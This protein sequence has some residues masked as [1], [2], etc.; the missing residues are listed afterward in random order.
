MSELTRF[1]VL[2]KRYRVA[3]GLTQKELAERACLSVR[4]ISN[5]ERGVR[6]LPQHATIELLA[7]AL[8]LTGPDRATF[9]AAARGHSALC[10]TRSRPSLDSSPPPLV[11]RTRALAMLERHLAGEGPPVLLLA[12]EPGIGKTRLL[13]EVIQQAEGRGWAVLS[14]GCQRRG[15]QEPY[16]P[17]LEALECYIQQR[18][19]T[20]LRLDLQ[21]CAWVVRLLPELAVG[22]IEP[23]RPGRCRPSRSVA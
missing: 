6:R 8:H 19:P 20:P 22:P 7:A 17:L 11:G 14:G 4:G 9:E 2:L 10:P 15:G 18:A 5:L 12:G 1:A 3:A 23:L 16:A 21:G 13:Q